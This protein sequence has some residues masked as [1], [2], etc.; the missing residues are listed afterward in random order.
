MLCLNCGE[1]MAGYVAMTPTG[2]I[3][4]TICESCGSLWLDRSA[5]DKMAFQVEGSIEASSQEEVKA[6]TGRP[7]PR[8]A[9]VDLEEV[10]FL[11]ESHIMLEKC[12]NCGGFWLDGGELD[13][14]NRELELVMPVVGQGF[15][16][17]VNQV[18]LPYWHK[19]VRR[20]PEEFESAAG[21]PP[22]KGAEQV[23]ET[24]KPC[25]ACP[26]RLSRYRVWGLDFEGCAQCSGLWL[27]LEK[28]R[29]LK[30]RAT[31]GTWRAL[32][33]MDDELEAI[34]SAHAVETDRPCPDC[35]DRT[36]LATVFGDS[37]LIVDW[38]PGCRKVWL[39]ACEFDLMLEHLQAELDRMSPKDLRE[40]LLEELKEVVS[41]PESPLDELRD[42]KAALSA[43]VN[44][45]IF[46]HPKL[47]HWLINLPPA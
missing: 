25:P 30:D 32:N 10:R 29:D 37:G 14:V 24:D 27:D 2:R 21:A 33:W 8:C 7:C 5:L 22:I 1:K 26:N 40:Q 39:D 46:N 28:L 38:C 34:G 42:A 3:E 23:G 12:P 20:P 47:F 17:F 16:E 35:P 31:S 4:Y 6:D 15:S 18:H 13:L 36:L 43:L 41:G 11:G 45:T 19:R 9:N 44:V